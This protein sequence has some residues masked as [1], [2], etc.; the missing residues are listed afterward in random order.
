MQAAVAAG[1]CGMGTTFA[2]TAEGA[3]RILQEALP[4]RDASADLRAL[5]R[6]IVERHRASR[7]SLPG[8]G[9]PAHKPVDP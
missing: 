6:Q 8:I 3:A 5:A 1:L 4:T 7:Q 2:G 9:H